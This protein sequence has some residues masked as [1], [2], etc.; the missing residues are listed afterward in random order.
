MP[1]YYNGNEVAIN[2]GISL[3]K[4]PI[5]NFVND[6][7]RNWLAQNSLNIMGM[8][9]TADD[10][11]MFNSVLNGVASTIVSTASGNPFAVGMSVVSGIE[12]VIGSMI[13]KQAHEMIPSTVRGQL[14][15]AD[16]NVAS[17]K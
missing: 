5:C 9:M 15:T 12:G 8:T 10:I 3:G 11:N 4:F 16:L 1:N 14:N 2:D 6:I 7:Y 13:S 17:R